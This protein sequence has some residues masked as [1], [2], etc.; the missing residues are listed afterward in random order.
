MK[1]FL[2]FSFFFSLNCF[3]KTPK[4]AQKLVTLEFTKNGQTVK[5]FSLAEIESGRLTGSNSE[6]GSID[7]TLFN[8]FRAYTRT[9][10]G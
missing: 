1:Y 9:Y 7:V 5:T 4:V 8:V 6:V 3:S 10:R 2:L